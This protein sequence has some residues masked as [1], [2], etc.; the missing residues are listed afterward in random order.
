MLP[1]FALAGAGLAGGPLLRRLPEYRRRFLLALGLACWLTASLRYVTGFDYRSYETIF[2]RCAA[3]GLS[4]LFSPWLPEPGFVLL[5]LAA[6]LPGGG[7]RAFL[8][9]FHLLLTALVFIWISRYSPAPWLSAYLF[10]TLQYFAMSMNLLRQSL[11][12]AVALWTYPFLRRR[13][14]LPFCAVTLLAAGFHKSALVILPLYF[15]LNLRPS[16]RRYAIAAAAAGAVYLFLDPLLRLLLAVLP[17]YR[18][19][20]GGTYWQGNSAVYLLAPLGCFLLTLPLIRQAVRDPSAS[21]VLANAAVC[22]LLVQLFITRHFILER[23]SIYT[24]FFSLLSLPEAVRASGERRAGLWT[25]LVVLFGLAYLLF[26]ASQGFHGAYPYHGVW[27]RA[28]A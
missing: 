15:L 5:N 2:Q 6:S 19:Y 28:A 10:V 4:G 13:R 8:F 24:A 3:A 25:A 22:T 23:L 18:S 17:V 27:S 7:Y 16:P 26:A 14:F 11:A 1:Y 12:A 21:P 9:L 20:P